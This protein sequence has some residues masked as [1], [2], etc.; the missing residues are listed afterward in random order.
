[1]IDVQGSTEQGEGESSPKQE[2]DELLQI[3]TDSRVG[4]DG[5]QNNSATT[6]LTPPPVLNGPTKLL[7]IANHQD[8]GDVPLMFQMFTHYWDKVLLWVMDRQFKYTN[9]GLVSWTHGDYFILPGKFVPNDLTKHC[10]R[11]PEKNCFILFPE[12]V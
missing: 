2:I 4:V 8:T 6:T 9:F 10:R 11:N 12:G 5:D 7:F 3:E 1:M